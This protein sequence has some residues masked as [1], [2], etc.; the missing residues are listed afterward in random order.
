VLD[1]F[2]DD[3]QKLSISRYIWNKIH[4]TSEDPMKSLPYAPYIMHVIE[5]V[6]G[7]RFPTDAQHKLLKLANKM[8]ISAAREL[9]RAAETAK[10]KGKGV[11]TSRSHRGGASPSAAPSRSTSAEPL[12]SSSSS[13]S[14]KPGKFKFLMNYMF[15]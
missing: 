8:S 3:F 12:T 10:G 2:G 9:K 11:S 5:Q 7:I 13:K 6:S 4:D 1:R 14:K 15:G